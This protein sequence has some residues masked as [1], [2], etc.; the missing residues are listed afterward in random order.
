MKEYRKLYALSLDSRTVVELLVSENPKNFRVHQPNTKI[1]LYLIKKVNI[2]NASH[3]HLYSFNVAHLLEMAIEKA[4]KNSDM[5]YNS[6]Y[7]ANNLLSKYE[8]M[9]KNI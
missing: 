1:A 4:R 5:F 7:K 9:L 3:Y 2:D 6:Y 8:S